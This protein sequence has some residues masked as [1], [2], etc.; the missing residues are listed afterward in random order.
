MLKYYPF[1]KR[2]TFFLLF[3]ILFFY[4]LIIARSFFYPICLAIVF[5]YLLYP[6]GRF[7]EKH[8]VPRIAANFVCLIV[9]FAIITFVVFFISSQLEVFVQEFPMLKIKAITNIDKIAL[10]L[11][12]EIGVSS[13][14]QKLWLKSRIEG[15]FESGGK[16]FSTAFNATAGTLV[17]LGILP[18][19]VFFFLYYRNKFKEFF[20]LIVPDRIHDKSHKILDEVSYVTKRYMT[21]ITTVVFILC[22][23]NSIGLIIVGIDY[24]VLLG[25]ISAFFNFIPYFGTLIGG[26]IPFLVALITMDSPQYAV[27]VAV[28]FLFIQ[29]LE[30]NI[31]TPNITGGN[32]K[33]NPLVTILSIIVGGLVWGVPGMFLSVPFLAMFKIVCDHVEPL[34]PISFL[35]GTEGTEKHALTLSK[36]RGLFKKKKDK[37]DL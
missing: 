30:N 14:V 35:L 25:I 11:E 1:V 34:Q 32:V 18:V 9:A 2:A 31:L 33:L 26:L 24:P 37:T 22:F 20:L 10:G 15:L 3:T 29:F 16:F 8:R 7:L 4:C 28:L 23:V 36:L 13:Q 21:G 12:N 6:L 5:S 17:A 19:Y 27:G